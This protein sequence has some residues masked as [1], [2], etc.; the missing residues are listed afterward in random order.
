MSGDEQPHL[1]ELASTINRQPDPRLLPLWARAFA[2]VLGT[3]V[4]AR[5]VGAQDRVLARGRITLSWDATTGVKQLDYECLAT[6]RSKSDTQEVMYRG[7]TDNQGSFKC[8]GPRSV[9][10]LRRYDRIIIHAPGRPPLE[11][12]S[13]DACF[14][15][16]II[17]VGACTSNLSMSRHAFAVAVAQTD[18]VTVYKT[19]TL[20]FQGRVDTVT[21]TNTVTRV[22]TVVPM[23]PPPRLA[24]RLGA[25]FFNGIPG[26]RFGESHA[27]GVGLLLPLVIGD[28]LS[29][30]LEV[31][32]SYASYPARANTS[33]SCCDQLLQAGAAILGSLDIADARTYFGLGPS[34]A[35]GFG[36]SIVG[37]RRRMAGTVIVGVTP[38]TPDRAPVAIEIRG[39][40]GEGGFRYVSFG[41]R[42]PAP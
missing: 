28:A 3:A 26:G 29:H 12:A 21:V 31:S 6:L 19:D 15:D 17:S 39:T 1:M 8:L 4:A 13:A 34:F 33:P 2:L 36:D 23:A 5:D 25:E 35:V 27:R 14:V 9:A 32:L 30:T 10:Q 40:Y 11:E 16:R 18:T 38:L 24:T 42:V 22:D 7:R 37:Q 41:V 20:R